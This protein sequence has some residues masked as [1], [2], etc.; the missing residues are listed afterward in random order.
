MDPTYNYNI[1]KKTLICNPFYCYKS[2]L[3]AKSRFRFCKVVLSNISKENIV[4]STNIYLHQ[5]PPES[6]IYIPTTSEKNTPI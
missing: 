2:V 5:Q 4:M 1:R 3:T 6:N